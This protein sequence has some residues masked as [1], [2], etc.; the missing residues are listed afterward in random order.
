MVPGRC[1][2]HPSRWPRCAGRLKSRPSRADVV[3]MVFD[4]LALALVVGGAYAFWQEGRRALAVLPPDDLPPEAARTP[5]PRHARLHGYVAEGLD[6]IDDFL[7]GSER[8]R[9]QPA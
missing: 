1:S 5:L 2:V 9:D 8:D 7:A 6:D 3:G 4:V